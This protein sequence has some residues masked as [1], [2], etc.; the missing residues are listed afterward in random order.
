MA[1]IAVRTALDAAFHSGQRGNNQGVERTL[2]AALQSHHLAEA[3]LA[4]GDGSGLQQLGALPENHVVRHRAI[5]LAVP[6]QT[7][8]LGRIEPPADPLHRLRQEHGLGDRQP[9]G[10][11]RIGGLQDHR[12]TSDEGLAELLLY[13]GLHLLPATEEAGITVE[14]PADRTA[15]EVADRWLIRSLNRAREDAS[16]RALA[17]GGCTDH[18]MKTCWSDWHARG[19]G[20]ETLRAGIGSLKSR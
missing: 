19:G 12:L 8:V 3:F 7:E 9:E 5:A 4:V 11:F 2:L 20:D 10:P 13:D 15:G 6:L 1:G 17:T 18:Q 14:I 16:G